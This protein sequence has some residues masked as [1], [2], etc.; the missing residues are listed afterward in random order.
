MPIPIN[1]SFLSERASVILFTFV[2]VTSMI[3]G[4][5]STINNRRDLSYIYG[6]MLISFNMSCLLIQLKYF[7]TSTMII[8]AIW[9]GLCV[10]Y[11]IKVITKKLP[12]NRIRKDIIKRRIFSILNVSR[13]LFVVAS[14]LLTL[15]F[16]YQFRNTQ[17]TPVVARLRPS[18]DATYTGGAHIISN[19]ETLKNIDYPNWALL[20][21]DEKLDLLQGIINIEA[22]YLGLPE[23]P[24]LRA[25]YLG[26]PN[27]LGDYNHKN[28][29]IRIALDHLMSYELAGW[30]AV[31]TVIHECYHSYQHY[32]IE[33][34]MNV[35]EK[36]MTLE[37]YRIVNEYRD[38]LTNHPHVDLDY[39]FSSFESDARLYAGI[40][41][42]AYI[43]HINNY[44]EDQK[45]YHLSTE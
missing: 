7:K 18:H 38:Y 24:L 42:G 44:L 41:S 12:D 9:L 31:E 5:I 19:I 14:L 30:R 45:E 15:L 13:S 43:Y 27:V 39:Y 3:L 29:T 32:L 11:F 1:G 22:V 34:I 16:T 2:Y 35:D 40:A 23:A 6:N 20:S 28:K 37:V 4:T 21:T 17:G 25:G 10:F 33:S 8:L 26:D 36:H